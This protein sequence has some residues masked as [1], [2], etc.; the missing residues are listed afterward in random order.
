MPIV[1]HVTRVKHLYFFCANSSRVDPLTNLVR[2]VRVE[3]K[4]T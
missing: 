3:K 4:Y 1:R 2:T